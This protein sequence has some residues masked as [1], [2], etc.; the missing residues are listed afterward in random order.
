MTI[1][2]LLFLST[3]ILLINTSLTGCAYR[4]IPLAVSYPLTTQNKMQSAHHW[5]VLAQH[6]ADRFAQTLDLTFPNAVVKPALF[7]RYSQEQEK[8]P[9]ARAFFH[10]LTAKLVQKGL[11]VVSNA[12]ST[13]NTLV[14]DYEMQ[15]V[16]HQDRRKR[17]P[18]LGTF[19][20]LG[21]LFWLVA[22]GIDRWGDANLTVLP[23]AVG[24][25][26]YSGVNYYFPGETNTEVIITT[27]LTMGQQYVFQENNIYYI[28]TGDADHYESAGKTYQLVSCPSA[29]I[30]CR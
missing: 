18:P 17:Y 22:R 15:I 19:S 8:I 27:S 10:M 16:Q 14:A 7:I 25:D 20:A 26:I 11:I 5:E 28:N 23:L 30:S 4:G 1:K 13:T 24:A 29:S 6:S 2:N 12:D 9:F 3:I 21:S